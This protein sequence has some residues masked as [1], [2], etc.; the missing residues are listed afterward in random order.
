MQLVNEPHALAKYG[1]ELFSEDRKGTLQQI[2]HRVRQCKI[3]YFCTLWIPFEAAVTANI[4]QIADPDPP[5]VSDPRERFIEF[6][7]K[8]VNRA[9]RGLRVVG[10]LSNRRIY[11]YIEADAKKLIRAL[12]AEIKGLKARFRG[13]GD[14]DCSIFSF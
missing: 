2:E 9:L 10:N 3:G 12:Q 14:A 1:P 7:N 4:N 11:K 13:D 6:A 5:S 8:R